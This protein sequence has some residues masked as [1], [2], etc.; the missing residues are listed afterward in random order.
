MDTSEGKLD[1]ILNI[2]EDPVSAGNLDEEPVAS[3]IFKDLEHD[4]VHGV[5]WGPDHKD[6][7]LNIARVIAF[8]EKAS[9]GVA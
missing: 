7:S 2:E 6:P 9:H 8:L 3:C 1:P 5:A 4:A